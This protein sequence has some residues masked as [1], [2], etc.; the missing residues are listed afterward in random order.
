MMNIE[1]IDPK[2]KVLSTGMSDDYNIAI[3]NG[4]NMVRVE[5]KFLV[6]EI[7]NVYNY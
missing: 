1:S 2:F 6:K 4:S 3:K 7:I 5:V